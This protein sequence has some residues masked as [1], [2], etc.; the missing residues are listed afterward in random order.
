MVI[1]A[2]GEEP[3]LDYLL[4]QP[5]LPLYQG[6]WLRPHRDSSVL[7]GVFAAGDASARTFGGCGGVRSPGRTFR[8][9]LCYG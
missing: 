1:Q 6:L 7:P 3:V 8:G 4:H 2:I 5:S 9:C